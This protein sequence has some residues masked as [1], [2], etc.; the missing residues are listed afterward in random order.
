MFLAS[1]LRRRILVRLE[2]PLI[3]VRHRDTFRDVYDG[4]QPAAQFVTDHRSLSFFLLSI[5]DVKMCCVAACWPIVPSTS[6]LMAHGVF[7]CEL[8]GLLV[9]NLSK[10]C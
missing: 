6:H 5:G 1:G 7:W 4:S 3:G 2:R 10:N 8:A 9:Q